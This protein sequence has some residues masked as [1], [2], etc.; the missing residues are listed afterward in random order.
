MQLERCD[1][2]NGVNGGG[3]LTPIRVVAGTDNMMDSIA[4]HVWRAGDL[5]DSCVLLLRRLDFAG[6]TKRH[7][8]RP[9]VAELP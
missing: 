8:E 2:C 1:N 3:S 5:C 6:F 9:R 4:N 7:C